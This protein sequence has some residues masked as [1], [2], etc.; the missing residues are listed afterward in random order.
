MIAMYSDD[1]KFWNRCQCSTVPRTSNPQR[2][3]TVLLA[4]IP[5]PMPNLNP[6]NLATFPLHP[7]TWT[8]R[9]C[10]L[11]ILHFWPH[12]L[13]THHHRQPT[14]LW[15]FLSTAPIAFSNTSQSRAKDLIN[16]PHCTRPRLPTSMPLAPT[17]RPQLKVDGIGPASLCM[18]L[19]QPPPLH[20]RHSLRHNSHSQ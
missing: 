20:Q 9:T 5:T 6:N 16:H 13:A 15:L 8:N 17:Q 18:D 12:I 7:C 11:N 2:D 1:S 14:P 3:V 19:M 10:M 4:G